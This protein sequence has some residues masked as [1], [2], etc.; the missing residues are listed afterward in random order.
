MGK[1]GRSK[2]TTTVSSSVLFPPLKQIKTDNLLLNDDIEPLTQLFPKVL[3]R[4]EPKEENTDSSNRASTFKTEITTT[5]STEA[6]ET[7]TKEAEAEAEANDTQTIL[8]KKKSKKIGRISL[9]RLK[10]FSTKPDLVEWEDVSAPD[11]RL[12][13]QLK[14]LPNTV[15]VPRHWSRKRKYLAGKRGFLKRP[16]DPPSYIKDTGI[17]EQR[18][19]VRMEDAAK[20]LK[21]KAREKMH[22]KLG[23]MTVDYESLYNAFFK[24]QTEPENLSTHGDLYWEGKE[25]SSFNV[26]ANATATAIASS[27]EDRPTTSKKEMS[28]GHLSWELREALGLPKDGSLELHPPP[29]LHNQQKV[30]TPPPSYP[31]QRIP[32][33]NAPIPAGAQWGFQN[34]G[35]G[36]PPV[37]GVMIAAA[38]AAAADAPNGSEYGNTGYY[39]EDLTISKD[40]ICQSIIPLNPVVLKPWYQLVDDD[41]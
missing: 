28:P 38:A 33:L 22:P 16:F 37:G 35:W 3:E 29:W 7:T 31:Q 6:A 36:R 30:G 25:L 19:R 20:R 39:E 40:Q 34:G 4:F 15:P 32:G 14:E 10:S 21:V 23:R 1:R 9:A 17:Q 27:S 26:S 24:E 41:D 13:C 11:P 5:E 8:S 12:L 2:S 18:D